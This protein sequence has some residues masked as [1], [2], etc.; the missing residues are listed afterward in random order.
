LS[1]PLIERSEKEIAKAIKRRVESLNDVRN[2]HQ[3]SVRMI[4][5]RYDVD[6]HVSLD[7]NLKFEDVHRIAS[8]VERKVRTLLP[9]ARV[10]VHTEPVGSNRHDVWK[11]VRDMA[12]G[13]PGSR[14][15][16][17]IHVQEVDGK[18]YVDFHLEVAAGI[19]VKQ[20]HEI[21]DQVERKLKEANNSI[22]GITTHIESASDIISRESTDAGTDIAGY[23]EDAAKHFSEIKDVQG[24]VV[25]RVGSGYHIVLKCLFDPSL[26]I[27]KTHAILNKLE[28]TI[29][30]TYPSVSRID[31]HEEP[32]LKP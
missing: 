28:E 29:K 25:S 2:C 10:T 3:I 16:H 12:E 27:E 21:A 5:K 4:G 1:F 14:G 17:N 6:M 13:E 7:R 32:Y 15:V 24:I 23:I 19:T 26:S 22:S 9:K 18:I 8:D 31:I 11:L 30:S 20:A